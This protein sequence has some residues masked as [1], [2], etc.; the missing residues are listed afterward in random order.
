MLNLI[1]LLLFI[2]LFLNYTDELKD[3]KK[4]LDGNKYNTNLGYSYLDSCYSKFDNN[5]DLHIFQ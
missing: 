1:L 5:Y 2:I 4:I 3:D